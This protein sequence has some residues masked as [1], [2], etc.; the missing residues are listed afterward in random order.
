MYRKILL[1]LLLLTTLSCKSENSNTVKTQEDTIGVQNDTAGVQSNTDSVQSNTNSVQND[2][3]IVPVNTI[4]V[5]SAAMK[6]DIACVVILPDNYNI[7]NKYPTVYLLHGY[8]DDETGWITR[9]PRLTQLSTQLQMIIVCPNGERSWYFDSPI[10]PKMRFET[11]ISNELVNYIDNHYST[12]REPS[13]RAIT[14]LSMGG[15]GAMWNAI[16]HQDVFGWCGTMSG[17]VDIRPFPTRWEISK[18][19]G[20]Y[21]TNKQTWE[22]HTVI[23]Q[24]DKIRPGLGIIIDCGTEDFFFKVNQNLHQALTQR[25]IPHNYSTRPGNHSWNYWNVSIIYHL[26]FFSKG[27]GNLKVQKSAK[28]A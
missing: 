18:A 21:N 1:A 13:K 5:H 24:V 28:A 16:R 11:F 26:N 27:F 22:N 19:L 10:N 3:D 23:N 17:G 6:R 2:S 12:F 20:N 14:G 7:A 9:Q 25:K 15:H 4:K 8:G